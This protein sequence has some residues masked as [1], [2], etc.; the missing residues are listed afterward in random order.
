MANLGPLYQNQ[1]YSNLLQIDGGLTAELKPVLDGDGNA[2]G[3]T[4]S[5]TGV[6]ISGL[7]TDIA[8][9]LS[10]GAAGSIP[11]QSG[12]SDTNFIAA[13]AAGTVL[14]STGGG[15]PA[16]VNTIEY[17]LS[18][19]IANKIY[20][21]SAGQLVYQSSVSNTGFVPVGTA[22]QVLVSNGALGPSWTTSV[23][24]ALSANAATNIS[25]GA[26]GNLLYQSG[27][28]LTTYVSNGTAGQLLKS[29]GSSAPV[30]STI[31]AADVNAVPLNGS[32]AMTGDLSLG[33]HRITNVVDPLVS[34]DAATKAY[35][36]SVATGLK[37]KTACRVASTT[38]LTL[39]GLIAVDGV[40]VSVGDRVLIKDQTSQAQNGIY[41][42]ASGAWSRATDA[43]TWDELVGATTFISAGSTQANTTWACNVTAGGTLGTTAVTFVL[44]G[45]STSYT[46]GTGLT[47]IGSQFALATPVS[48]ANGGSGVATLTGI[49]KGNGASAF[50]AATGADVVSLIGV[51]AVQN[52][53]TAGSCS[54]NAASATVLQTARTINGVSFNGSAPI[55]VTA[56]TGTSLTFNNGGVGAASGSTWNGSAALTI[57]YNTIGAAAVNGTGITSPA[58]WRTSLEASTIG[59][60]LFT[61]T[62]PGAVTFPRFNADNTVSVLSASNTLNALLP[63]QTGNTGKV[64]TTDGVSSSWATVG[65]GTVTSV[66]GVLPVASSGGSTPAISLISGYGETQNP[67]NNK[68]ANYVLA[69]PNGVSG[70]PAF[71][72]L[73]AADIPTLN[74][75]TT[76]TAS[77][78]TGVVAAVNGGTGQSTYTIGDL[79]YASTS[80]ALSKLSDVATGN[81]LISGGVGAAPSWGKIGLTTHV[82]GILPVAN[83]GT[84]L[85]SPFATLGAL[86]AGTT[87]TITTGLLPIAYGGTNAA[88]VAAARVNL[89]PTYVG[90]AN[91][92]LAVNAGGTDVEWKAPSALMVY[93][94]AGIAVSTG[95][96][97]GTS[98]T[99]PTGDILGTNDTQIV[100]NKTISGSTNVLSNIAN[101]SL[102]NSAITING[103]PISLG[104]SV[105]ISGSSTTISVSTIAALKAVS[106]TVNQ[107]AYV[108]GYYAAGDGGG[109]NYYYDAADTTSTDNGGTI[110]VATDGGRW[111]LSWQAGISV[112][113]FGAYDNNT[114]PTTTTTA[115]Q[116][117]INFVAAQ[118]ENRSYIFV[119][120]GTYSLN[121]LTITNQSNV[122]IKG[123]GQG[124]ILSFQNSTTANGI[125]LTGTS[126][127]FRLDD[128]WCVGSG[129]ATAGAV[130]SL[131]STVNPSAFLNN[132]I[133]NNGYYGL[134][135]DCGLPGANNVFLT[136]FMANNQK[137]TGIIDYSGFWCANGNIN[138]A[139]V[140]GIWKINGNGPYVTNFDVFACTTGVRI[141]PQAGGSIGFGRYT[142]VT[143]SNGQYGYVL[144]AT[145]GPVLD[146]VITGGIGALCTVN[147]LLI[148]GANVNGVSVTGFDARSC[149]SHGVVLDGCQ[150]VIFAHSMSTGNT[151]NGVYVTANT[152]RFTITNNFIGNVAGGGNNTQ[153]GV[154]IATGTSNV[155][156]VTF[157]QLAGNTAGTIL[158]GG[159]GTNKVL[160]N[161]L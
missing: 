153:Y 116:L 100:T 131:V 93:P 29:Q 20:G 126:T 3:L 85:T 97:W 73:V 41:V 72:A 30:W 129:S 132:V 15:P 88:T 48:V 67:Y 101:A 87:T 106:K 43:D 57:S 125:S 127:L 70:A 128:V 98:K 58:T 152:N 24:S 44:F 151:G 8:S 108:E 68:T 141:A 160:A 65:T 19:N 137:H 10:G 52:A 66:T 17:S 74:Q 154:N 109:G 25:G 156:I 102:T 79:L 39:S 33:T 56:N 136:N 45:A 133:I 53:T 107:F 78:V 35:V 69:A 122:H 159:S 83:G 37:I 46:A 90:N 110:I 115:F 140:N 32:L 34:T 89:L 157:N 64:L 13:G 103:T 12:D 105:T 59:S 147:G 117:A 60:N 61:L 75:N 146:T 63:T 130:I 76:G 161:N 104:G 71:R 120:K 2:S 123:C 4:L 96:A 40:T 118:Q 94:S 143:T 16:W 47:L 14:S 21:G 114:N 112:K 31:T 149:S 124:S 7:V 142:N 138:G 80:T 38:N 1:T 91:S 155:Y 158:D 99:T 144:D 111:K 145:N 121:T 54:G 92:V 86:Y 134:L 36:D 84:G 28:G 135:I 50:T 51:T 77:N 55:T 95:T 27:A 81:A 5:L 49:I 139:T 9:N 6:G 23:A 26:S 82:S 148:K 62:N 42:A 113:Q 11:F 18:S 22:G 119:P 150:N